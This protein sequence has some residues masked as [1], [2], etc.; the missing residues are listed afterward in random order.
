MKLQAN[1][2]GAWANVDLPVAATA[3]ISL[4]EDERLKRL[5]NRL[6]AGARGRRIVAG[7]TVLWLWHAETGWRRPR[8]WHGC[9]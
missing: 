5:S 9:P 3:D 6:C 2:R 1:H 4:P 7:Q 8:W